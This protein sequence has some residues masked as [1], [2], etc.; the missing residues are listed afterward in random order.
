MLFNCA[1]VPNT[2]PD[3]DVMLVN[4][5]GLRHLTERVVPKMLEHA[6]SAIASIASTAGRRLAA[7]HGAVGWIARH[8]RLRRRARHGA[9]RILPT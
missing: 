4:F 6:D 1:G 7:E 5:C 2:F 3:L 8:R 9:T